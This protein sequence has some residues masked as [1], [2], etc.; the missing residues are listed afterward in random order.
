MFSLIKKNNLPQIIFL[1]LLITLFSI[2]ILYKIIN[3]GLYLSPDSFIYLDSAK[4]IYQGHGFTHSFVLTHELERWEG[5]TTYLP[6]RYWP[7]GFPLCIC[8]IKAIGHNISFLTAGALCTGIAY[9][10]TFIILLSLLFIHYNFKTCLWGIFFFFLFY[11]LVY[12]YSWVWSDG[13]AIPFLLVSLWLTTNPGDSHRNRYLFFAGLTAG[14][15][16]SIRY[17]MGILLPYTILIITLVSIQQKKTTLNKE[18]P[19]LQ[20]LSYLFGWGLI[21]FPILIRNKIIIGSFLGASRPASHIPILKNIQYTFVFLTNEILPPNIIPSEV[22]PQVIISFF[23]LCILL[24]VIRRNFSTIKQIFINQSLLTF[25]G[26]G[27]FYLAILIIY[28]SYYQIDSLS[29]RLL[30]PFT[31]TLIIFLATLCEKIIPFP[32]WV[33]ASGIIILEIFFFNLYPCENTLFPGTV[34]FTKNNARAEWV[35]AN[36]KPD[37][38]IIGDSTFDLSV[39]CPKCRSLC[40]VPA[41]ILDTPPGKKD[42]QI[43]FK[44][45][46]SQT[47]R[48]F[49]IL[50]KGVPFEKPYYDKWVEY[51]GEGITRLFFEGKYENIKAGNIN[52]GKGFLSA[53]IFLKEE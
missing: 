43:F 7:P 11:P 2:I 23:L 9:F 38:W 13:I 21:S 42:F 41:S 28:A 4:N 46:N 39:Y 51:Y 47:S 3:K 29:H 20:I 6:V 45:I 16:F 35:C 25:I 8:I 17:I 1:V 15:A 24:I 18:S 37:D 10:I 48:V 53:E 50:R 22:Q 52:S 32:S 31:I 33:I 14:F 49:I 44:K 40:F 12:T 19:I 5:G 36:T 27:L 26:W 30:L 34:S